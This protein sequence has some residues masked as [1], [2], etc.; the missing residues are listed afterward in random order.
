MGDR[1]LSGDFYESIT[2]LSIDSPE[3]P[4]NLERTY[5]SMDKDEETFIGK[6]WRFTY[7]SYLEIK[8]NYGRVTASYLNVRT[9]PGTNYNSIGLAPRDSILNLEIENGN[10]KT[11]NG[12]WYKVYLSNGE[13][14]VHK[15]YINIIPSGVEIKTEAGRSLVFDYDPDTGEYISSYGNYSKIFKSND[16]YI[17]VK[18]DMTKYEYK[19]VQ[20]IICTDCR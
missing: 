16:K 18:N 7:D 2:D 4:I 20:E 8:Q 15:N 19:K 5:N 11:Y 9:G 14:Y 6:G 12:N 10:A 17:L 3:I 1:I 13:Y